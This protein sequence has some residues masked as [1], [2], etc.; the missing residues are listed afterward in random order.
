MVLGISA[1]LGIIATLLPVVS[2]SMKADTPGLAITVQGGGSTLGVQTWQG[3]IC[4]I[5]Y[6]GAA[7]LTFLLYQPNRSTPKELNWVPIAVGGL[8]TILALWL[9]INAFRASTSVGGLGMNVT[10]SPSFGAFLNLL[11]ALG[12]TAGGAL[13]AREEKLF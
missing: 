7:V 10:V 2:V 3:V 12:V 13:K 4:L 1:V 8:V 11:T 6:L 9:L 5:G